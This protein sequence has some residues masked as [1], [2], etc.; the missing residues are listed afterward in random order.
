MPRYNLQKMIKLMLPGI[1]LMLLAP[2]IH[3]QLHDLNIIQQQLLNYMPP[4]LGGLAIILCISFNQG[5][6][7]LTTIN[8]LCLF[9]LIQN[10]LQTSLSQPANF[11]LFSGLS[12]LFPLLQLFINF[13]PERGLSSR[14]LL[15]HLPVIISGY[16][17][18]WLAA[19]NHLLS[20]WFSA[21][22]V[23]LIQMFS[24]PYLLSQWAVYLFAVTTLLG[25]VILW[26]RATLA[27]ACLVIIT[28]A[29]A[30][31]LALFGET[32][33][34]V[35]SC[36][37]GLILILFT[38]LFNSYSMAFIDELTGLPGRRALENT[39][40]SAGRRY[41]LG[42]VDIDHFKKFNDTYGHDVGDQ[43][44]R[45]VASQMKQAA[46]GASVFRYGGEEFTI[47]FKG[48]DEVSAIEIAEK[49]RNTIAAYP[50]RIRDKNRPGDEKK[51]RQQRNRSNRPEGTTEVTIS[52][53]L[54]EKTPQHKDSQAVIK[55]ADEA[56]YLA[57]QQG[58]NRSVASHIAQPRARKTSS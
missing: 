39:L 48:M 7:L 41:T 51:G 53:G 23:G 21:L 42:M 33:V 32:S 58:R 25:L 37:L 12:L 10:Q 20:A 34:S 54:C 38:V 18:F 13:I 31:M 47:V 2:V 46:R 44:L 9:L 30:A 29:I 40:R 24:D 35:L 57:K 4:L 11:V 27:D 3:S 22:P 14:W 55:Q 16:L 36:T 52:I 5:R 50:M 28:L 45:M 15:R 1:F 8:L 17:F 6:L 49:V 26:F 56:L 19:Q 43:V